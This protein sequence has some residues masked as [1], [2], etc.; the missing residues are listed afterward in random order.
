MLGAVS[1]T[2]TGA[3]LNY[4]NAATGTTGTTTT[5]LVFSTSPTL[6]TPSLGVATATSIN[7]VAITAPATSATLTIAD[8][9]TFTV[10][11]TLTLSGT[12]S[13]ALNIGTGGTL[14]TGAYA[15]I[16]NYAPLVSP[17]FTTPSLGVATATSLAIAGATIGSHKLAVSGSV[18]ITGGDLNMSGGNYIYGN[19]TSP[20]IRLTSGS[21]AKM[22]WIDGTGG[23]F[24]AG[25]DCGIGVGTTVVLTVKASYVGINYNSDPTSGNKLAVNGNSYFAGTGIFTSTLE[26]QNGS[27]VLGRT[28]GTGVIYFGAPSN[29]YIY[30]DGTSLIA[31]L[32]GGD[33]LTINASTG[34]TTFAGSV[35]ISRVGATASVIVS[36]T[37]SGN[38]NLAFQDGGT[39]NKAIIGWDRTLNVFR[40][41]TENF[42][43]AFMLDMAG[44]ASFSHNLSIASTKYF[45]LAGNES[46][47]GSWR[48]MATTS[49]NC[50]IEYRASGSWTAKTTITP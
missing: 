48:M 33:K 34:N 9:K 32:G 14:G 11:N 30:Y 26:A 15:T 12:D 23:Y 41:S 8:G 47:D 29:N 49:G 17:S 21:G 42:G 2:T 25:T 50:V 22:G 40:I 38:S 16:A 43:N 36:S 24:V 44:A 39:I 13:A 10:S 6:I 27:L 46:T 1:V 31:R 18:S 5:N 37:T 3:Q 45:Y 4:L 28:A 7:K 19:T 20:F 35:T